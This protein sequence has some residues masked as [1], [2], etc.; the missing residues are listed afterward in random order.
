MVAVCSY[1]GEL[2]LIRQWGSSLVDFV[3]DYDSEKK[4]RIEQFFFQVIIRGSAKN[5][6][7]AQLSNQLKITK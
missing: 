7:M 5:N 2:T 4:L 3:L 6:D 1:T